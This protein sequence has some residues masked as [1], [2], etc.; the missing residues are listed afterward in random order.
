MTELSGEITLSHGIP[1]EQRERTAQL[2]D[3][4]FGEKLAL[5][6][7]DASDRVRLLSKSLQLEFSIGAYDGV[8]LIGVAGF[9]TAE[10]SLTGGLGYRGLISELGLIKGSRAAVVL[11]LYD[12]K[13][14]SGELL[15]DGIVVDPDYRNNGVGSRLFSRL[16]AFAELEQYETIRLDVIDTNPGARRLYAHLGFCEEK[17]ERFEFLRGLL[18]FGESTT[19]ILKL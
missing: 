17:T 11:S 15:M 12:R 9:A 7:P 3:V 4:A 5:A 2:Y 18:G 19:M 13:A 8:K 1:A 14:K 6:I 16:M 10:G